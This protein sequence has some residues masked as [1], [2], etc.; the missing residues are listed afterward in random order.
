MKISV[1]PNF[2]EMSLAAADLVM[3]QVAL[4]PASLICFPSGA[5]PTKMFE[6]LVQYAREGKIDFSAC[7]FIGLD[8][9]LGMDENNEGS[10]KH[11]MYS[12]FF[13]PANISQDK[14]IFFN[15]VAPDVD[16]EC[17][18]INKFISKFG[19]LDI[20]MV[21]IGMNGHLG[22][23][24]PGTD[25][26]TYAH[27]SSLDPVTVKVGQKYFKEQTSLKEG[28]TLGLRHLKEAKT[29][30][31]IAAGTK[32]AAIVAEAIEGEVDTRVP[33]SI[34][35]TIS[36]ACILLDHEAAAALKIST[37]YSA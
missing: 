3:A 25:F 2:E 15:A 30:V 24:E 29:A 22:L 33:A 20:M 7:Y 34:L 1:Y 36:D 13:N 21:G 18:R 37:Y 27:R 11:Y 14:I 4:K 26:D 23:N 9:W 12:H 5:S 16:Q 8:E 10:C 19:G 17:E 32:K 31:L 28:I 6:Y 35:Q